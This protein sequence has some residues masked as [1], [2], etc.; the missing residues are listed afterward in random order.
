MTTEW[1]SVWTG[2]T[3]ILTFGLLLA[4]S[5]YAWLTHRLVIAG[6]RQSW[7]ISRPRL[8][9][10]LRTNQ[11]GQLVVLHIENIGLTAAEKLQLVIDRP[12]FQTFGGRSDVRE[13]PIFKQG[14]AALPPQTQVRI[15]LGV[16]FEYFDDA[17]D[18]EKHP[19]TFSIQASYRAGERLLNETF[20][21][22]MRDQ[23][24]GT[25]AETNY[26]EDFARKFP[27]QFSKAV[28]SLAR[29]LQGK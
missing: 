8:V 21:L 13:I 14:L 25:L 12:V 11:G 6:E 28:Q 9:V 10:A 27:D 4:T 18:R 16:A 29:A 17:L 1:G 23:L 2:L 24:E 5:V 22:N 20:T 26:V 7:E 19:L 15:G 3:A